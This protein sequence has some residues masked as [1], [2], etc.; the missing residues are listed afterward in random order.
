[1][2]FFFKSEE[3]KIMKTQYEHEYFKLF[4]KFSSCSYDGDKISEK[5]NYNRKFSGSPSLYSL[6]W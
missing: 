5:K 2:D 1:M 4:G 6:S 3:Y